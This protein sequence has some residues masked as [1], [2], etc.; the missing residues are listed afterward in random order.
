MSANEPIYESSLD[1]VNEY[2]PKTYVFGQHPDDNINHETV[3]I[4]DQ[5]IQNKRYIFNQT[6]IP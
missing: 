5:V 2:V 4:M 6:E 3:A 1:V